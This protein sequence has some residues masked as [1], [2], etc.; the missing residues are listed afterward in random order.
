MTKQKYA[1]K[2]NSTNKKNKTQNNE[3]KK[4]STSVKNK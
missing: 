4:T 1:T 3:H 2:C